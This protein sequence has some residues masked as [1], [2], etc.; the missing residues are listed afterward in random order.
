MDNRIRRLS[1]SFQGAAEITCSKEQGFSTGLEAV[2]VFRNASK[3]LES[4][5]LAFVQDVLKARKEQN[6]KEG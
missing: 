2:L 3:E 1:L 5:R 6:G 4:M